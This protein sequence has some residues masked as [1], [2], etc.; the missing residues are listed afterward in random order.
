MKTKTVEQLYKNHIAHLKESFS[1]IIENSEFEEIVIFS[2][3]ELYQFLDDMTYPFKANPHF[4]YWVPLTMHPNCYIKFKPGK[5][6]TLFYYKAVDFW[7]EMATAPSGFWCDEF[8]II[9]VSNFNET[10]KALGSNSQAAFFGNPIDEHL[11]WGFKS[12]NPKAQESEIHYLRAAKTEYEQFCIREANKLGVRSHLAAKDAFYQGANEYEINNAFLNAAGTLQENSPYGNIVALNQ[13]GS[14]L[15][16]KKCKNQSFSKEETYSFLI[17]AGISFQ[18]YA[19]DITRTYSYRD[20]EFAQLI[21]AMDKGHLNILAKIELNKAN[22]N[23]HMN[24]HLEVAKILAE[25]KFLNC[26]VEEILEKR[27][28]RTF[29]PHG[30]GHLLGIQIHDVGGNFKNSQGEIIPAPKQDP[31]LRCTRK[32]EQDFVFTIEPGLYFITPLLDDLKK[33]ENSSLVNWPK[34]ESFMKYGGI[35]IEDNIC[36]KVDGIENYT[37]D[38]Y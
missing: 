6:P 33:S 1:K 31:F 15:H 8:E 11:S 10:K 2:G 27:L 18:G 35:R 3:A 9:E 17:D 37:R 30:V 22:I 4:K 28:V 38:A 19:S 23:N 16:Y 7:H 5:K 26:S 20:D 21:K 12:M 29:Y 34:V 25:F 36:L 14:I 13:H 32:L 24:S